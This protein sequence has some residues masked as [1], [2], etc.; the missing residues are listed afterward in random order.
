[1][2][3]SKLK[4]VVLQLLQYSILGPLLQCIGKLS[5]VQLYLTIR[6]MA[7]T[8]NENE[9]FADVTICRWACSSRYFKESQ[10]YI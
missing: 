10:S 1:M 7:T 6:C 5:T 4:F 2:W 8:V 9:F 3:S